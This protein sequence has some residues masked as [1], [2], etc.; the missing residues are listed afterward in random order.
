MLV[1]K[2]TRIKVFS[3][4]FKEGVLCAAKDYKKAKHDEIDVP[5]LH[6]LKLLQSLKSRGFVR[7]TFNWQWYYWYLTDEGIEYLREFLHLPLEIV[8]NT[9]KKSAAGQMPQRPERGHFDRSDRPRK[10]FE[11]GSGFRQEQ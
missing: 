6:V 11:R 2:A 7:E 1:P 10:E 3:H 5:N 4:L 9:L 8:P